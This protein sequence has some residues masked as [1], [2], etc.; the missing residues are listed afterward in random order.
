MYTWTAGHTSTHLSCVLIKTLAVITF[1]KHSRHQTCVVS[2]VTHAATAVAG[3]YER[4]KVEEV[5]FLGKG[6]AC[7]HCYRQ[8]L[9]FTKCMHL[10]GSQKFRWLQT[11]G[12]ILVE[13]SVI[14]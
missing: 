12:W 1:T 6:W 7:F 5:Y 8:S 10:C 3:P 14:N 2:V 13:I 4:Q 9:F 11:D